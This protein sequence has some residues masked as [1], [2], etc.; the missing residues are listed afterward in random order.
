MVFIS[1]VESLVFMRL[2]PSPPPGWVSTV[3]VMSG[4]AAVKASPIAW[5][6][7]APSPDEAMSTLISRPSPSPLLP[8]PMLPTLQDASGR[9]SAV[10]PTVPSRSLLV[11]EF[12]ISYLHV[13]AGAYR[14]HR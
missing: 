11:R 2:S 5:I 13:K 14:P 9:A 1:P 7:S 8:P 12:F 4:F 6:V 3:T 10:M